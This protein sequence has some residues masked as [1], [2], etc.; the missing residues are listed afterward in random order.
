MLHI[1]PDKSST[2][3]VYFNSLLATMAAERESGR[4]YSCAEIAEACGCDLNTV[5]NIEA[6]ALV[7]LRRKL[8]RAGFEHGEL[9][10]FA[11]G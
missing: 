2:F 7:K 8:K 9:E 5:R 6:K 1:S 3:L 11:R 10:S 4:I